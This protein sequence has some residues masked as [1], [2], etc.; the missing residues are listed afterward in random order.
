MVYDNTNKWA[1]WIKKAKSWLMYKSWTL[2]VEWKEYKITM[3]DNNYKTQ[4]DNKPDFNIVIE[5]IETPNDYDIKPTDVT[6]HN[7]SEDEITVEDIPF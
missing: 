4:W 1:I 5:R 7:I 6:K 2:N 3:F